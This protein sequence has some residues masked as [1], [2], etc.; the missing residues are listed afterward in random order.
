MIDGGSLRELI[1]AYE[2]HG[3]ILR[4]VLLSAD[5]RAS[6]DV[7]FADVPVI[8]SD[9]DA[10]WFSRPPR[11][12]GVAWELRYLGNIS[13]ALVEKLDENADDFDEKLHA[14]ESRLRDAVTRKRTA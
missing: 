8:A 1:A 13:Y 10:A 2:T 5:P 6:L 14:V 12:G 4:R 9:M 3:W 11:T 7:N